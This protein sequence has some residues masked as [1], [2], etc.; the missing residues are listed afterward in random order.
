MAAELALGTAREA[1]MDRDPNVRRQLVRIALGQGYA[2]Q[3][4]LKAAASAAMPRWAGLAL[5]RRE[6]LW[7]VGAAGVRVKRGADADGR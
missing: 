6:R 3:T 4:R 1:L 5:A 2:F 7:W